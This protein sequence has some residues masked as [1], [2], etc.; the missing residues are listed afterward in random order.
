[1]RQT[2]NLRTIKKD[3]MTDLSSSYNT[4]YKSQQFKPVVIPAQD[5][6]TSLRILQKKP[7]YNPD[8]ELYKKLNEEIEKEKEEQK[9]QLNES[10]EDEKDLLNTYNTLSP[11]KKT[12]YASIRQKKMN[13]ILTGKK[14]I[15]KNKENEEVQLKTEFRS[16]LNPYSTHWPSCFLKNGYSTGFCYSEFQGGVPVLRLRRL[17][18]IKTNNINNTNNNTQNL[19]ANRYNNE[20]NF[21]IINNNENEE[22]K[23]DENVENKKNNNVEVQDNAQRKNMLDSVKKKESSDNNSEH[24]ENKSEQ[25]AEKEDE[26]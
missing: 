22:A 3:Q 17:P 8:L 2:T 11:K 5:G 21:N 26:E 14:L 23:N 15:K 25:T 4:M 9:P 20:Q 13:L 16:S 1:M 6:K 24:S 10:D 12:D 18:P 19:A 7:V